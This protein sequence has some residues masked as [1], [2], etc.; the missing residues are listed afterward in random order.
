MSDADGGGGGRRPRV[1]GRRRL[2]AIVFL[3]VAALSVA[4]SGT[5]MATRGTYVD[6]VGLRGG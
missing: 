1:R 4:V 5:V 3:L 6:V 2:A